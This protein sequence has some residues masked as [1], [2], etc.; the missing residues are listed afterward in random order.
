MAKIVLKAG[1]SI[2]ASLVPIGWIAFLSGHLVDTIC[3]IGAILL[4]AV[5]RVLPLDIALQ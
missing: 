3:P 1:S 4:A 5:A 2:R